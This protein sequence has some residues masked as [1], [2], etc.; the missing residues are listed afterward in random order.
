MQRRFAVDKKPLISIIVPV[1]N[2]EKYLKATVDS[3]LCQSYEYI[4]II[5]VDDGSSDSSPAI[6]DEYAQMDSRVRVIHKPNGG[7]SSARNAALDIANGVYVGFCDSDDTVEPNTYELMLDNLMREGADVSVCGFN[8]VYPDRKEQSE[9]GESVVLD[10]KNALSSMLVGKHFEGHL[11][12]KL[13]SRTLIGDIRM[14]EDIQ[15][16]ED[17]LFVFS[18]MMN[19]ER[20]VYDPTPCYNYYMREDSACHTPMNKKQASAHRACERMME[21]AKACGRTELF[22]CIDAVT[23]VCNVRYVSRMSYNKEG[24]KEFAKFA[25]KNIRKHLNRRSLSLLPGMMKIR[26]LLASFSLHLYYPIQR[27]LKRNYM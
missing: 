9:G 11:W 13:F 22:P 26:A 6:C 12:D 14:A 27:I 10:G 3:L 19:A 2:A 4:E 17:M 18:V 7:V 24:R 5:L 8:F 23:V 20:V 21:M 15:V 1:Y 16:Y 25:K